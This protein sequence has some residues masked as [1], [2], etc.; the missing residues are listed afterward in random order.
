MDVC[1]QMEDKIL[2][3]IVSKLLIDLYLKHFN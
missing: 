1:W 3:R 2:L